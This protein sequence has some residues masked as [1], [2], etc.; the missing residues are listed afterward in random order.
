MTVAVRLIVAAIVAVGLAGG[1]LALERGIGPRAH[2]GVERGP[3]ASD[4]AYC[5]HGGGEGW[6]A[7]VVL[8]NAAEDAIDVRL[9][10]SSGGAP[11]SASEERMEP[12]T[13][14]YVEVAAPLPG[15]ATRVESFGAGVAAGMVVAAPEGGLAAEP[16]ATDAGTLWMLPE[17]STRR[18]EDARL[19]VQNPFAAEA[20]IDVTLIAA[21]RQLRPGR[22]QGLVLNPGES[23][24]ISLHNFAL[25]LDALG[26]TVEVPLGRVAVAGVTVSRGGVRASLGVPAFGPARFLPGLGT[27]G[28]VVIR[29]PGGT[30]VPFH[31][32]LHGAEG[33]SRLIDL[34]AIPAG[35]VEAF[36]APGADGGLVARVDGD[37]SMAAGRRMSLPPPEPP[38]QEERQRGGKGRKGGGRSEREEEEPPP[39]APSD[40]ASTAGVSEPSGRWIALPAVGPEGGESTLLIQ[41][42]A[43]EEVEATITFLGPDGPVGE[44]LVV[45]VLPSSTL[46]VPLPEGPP[47]AAVVDAGDGRLV[48]AQAATSA[49]AFAVAVGLA[50]D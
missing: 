40:V 46:R 2:P 22:L 20:V 31:A 50:L 21:E 45:S 13:S 25:G 29:A 7:W 39:P 6:R 4:A 10:T 1:G 37:R 30:E 33:G 8:A 34:E 44:P 41:N 38:A 16:C 11:P 49:Q 47:P 9:T 26:V 48:V 35:Q 17:T 32:E 18:G 36:P 15:T 3:V 42:P 27:V 5:P 12:G 24:A 28:D 43:A 23:R 19:L 14:R